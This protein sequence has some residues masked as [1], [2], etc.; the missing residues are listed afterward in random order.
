M[1][2]KSQRDGPDILLRGV[3]AQKAMPGEN[4]CACS[5]V[6]TPTTHME[7]HWIVTDADMVVIL[8][9]VVSIALES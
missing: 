8:T 2:S 7:R 4:M 6:L 3:D 5:K 1:A 9:N